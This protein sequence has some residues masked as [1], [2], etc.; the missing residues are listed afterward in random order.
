MKQCFYWYPRGYRSRLFDVF[1]F[2]WK[3]QG[4]KGP[5]R[6]L[7][8]LSLPSPL[9]FLLLSPSHYLPFYLPIHSLFPLNSFFFVTSYILNWYLRPKEWFCPYKDHRVRI[10][11][12]PC[13]DDNDYCYKDDLFVSIFIG[14]KGSHPPTN[15]VNVIVIWYMSNIIVRQN[16]LYTEKFSY[17]TKY[18]NWVLS[19]NTFIFLIEIP[20]IL[21]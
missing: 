5:K 10:L 4:N 9:P 1:T 15:S 14:L 2:V 12:L 6:R 11:V 8:S 19:I 16:L 21:K 18:Y 20:V 7:L 13:N 17:S 3:L